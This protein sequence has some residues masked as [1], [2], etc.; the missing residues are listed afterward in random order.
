MGIKVVGKTRGRKMTPYKPKKKKK[1]N[2]LK[3][4]I[5]KPKPKLESSRRIKQA[6]AHQ[7]MLSSTSSKAMNRRLAGINAKKNKKSY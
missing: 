3:K 1:K 2:D 7:G 5:E 6:A 4:Y